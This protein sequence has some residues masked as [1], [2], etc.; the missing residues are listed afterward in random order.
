MPPLSSDDGVI[1]LVA[2]RN[3]L[4]KNAPHAWMSHD[5]KRS[6]DYERPHRDRAH[7][8]DTD[9]QRGRLRQSLGVNRGLVTAHEHGILTSASMMV[10]W[11]AAKEAAAYA[12]EH[13][14]LGV[15]LHFDLGE[16]A[17]RRGTGAKLY[18]VVSLHDLD[19]VR[20]E[21]QR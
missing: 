9:R 5:Q 18:E 21:L 19:A 7:E 2:L 10:R 8:A 13:P 17:C 3:K 11:P 14:R 20:R 6:R 4:V 15:G 12:R 16:W 1:I